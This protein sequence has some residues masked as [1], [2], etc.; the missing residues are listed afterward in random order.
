MEVVF[1]IEMLKVCIKIGNGVMGIR[2]LE[3]GFYVLKNG[4][5]IL[6]KDFEDRVLY[7]NWKLCFVFKN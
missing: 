5:K 1:C 7:K 3:I 6:Y 2:I 4:N